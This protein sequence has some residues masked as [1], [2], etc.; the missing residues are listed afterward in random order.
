MA[1]VDN[2]QCGLVLHILPPQDL[3]ALQFPTLVQ[4]ADGPQATKFPLLHDPLLDLIDRLTEIGFQ[5]QGSRAVADGQ[6]HSG[7]SCWADGEGVEVGDLLEGP[8]AT[9]GGKSCLDW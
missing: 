2:E 3:R 6:G 9:L 8:I 7:V 4:Q 1:F 5:L